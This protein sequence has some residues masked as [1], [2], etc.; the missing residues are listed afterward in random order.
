MKDLKNKWKEVSSK[1]IKYPLLRWLFSLFKRNII[2]TLL[3][4]YFWSIMSTFNLLIMREILGYIDGEYSNRDRAVIF[5]IIMI[6][7]ELVSR[8]LGTNIYILKNNLS[9]GINLSIMGLIYT[10]IY[11]ISGSNKKYSKGTINNIIQSD[12][13]EVQEVVWMIPQVSSSV[14]G[15]LMNSYALYLIIGISS[16]IVILITIAL[17]VFTYFISKYIR[18]WNNQI[19]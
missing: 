13:S 9:R 6:F 14:F 11:K 19:K 5:V 4:E 15:F 10:K 8:V 2:V 18:N 1:E 7:F 3:I 12:T 17:T 16:I